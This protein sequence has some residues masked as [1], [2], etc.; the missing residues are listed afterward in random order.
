M[1]VGFLLYDTMIYHKNGAPFPERRRYS[2]VFEYMFVFSKGKPGTVNIIK[3]KKNKW[4]GYKNFGKRVMRGQDGALK[5]MPLFT[6][7]EYGARYNV[8]YYN[9]GKNYSTK[10]DYAFEHPAIFPEEL[11]EDH[12]LTWSNPKDVVLD[13]MCGSGT[14]L[15]MAKMNDRVFIG[16]DAHVEYVEL[17]KRRVK[18]AVPYTKSSPNPKCKFI[19]P[20]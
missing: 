7:A 19:E 10:D 6:I 18:E 13:P 17:S 16:I 14:T 15:K 3:D 20:R 4:A 9:T 12:I 11:A 1:E 2:Q 5:E 8:W